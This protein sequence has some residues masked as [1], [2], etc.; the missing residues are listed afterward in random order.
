MKVTILGSGSPL[1]VPDRAGPATLVQVAGHTLLFDCGRAVLMRAAAVGVAARDLDALFVTHMHSDH[2]TD[3][4]DVITTR[5]ISSAGVNPL[6]A[7][8][9]AGFDAFTA[10]T[11]A[12]L[13]ND[14][15]YRIGHHADLNEPPQVHV[16]EVDEGV[17]WE[18]EGVMVLAA[19]TDHSPVHPTVGFRVE[20]DGKSVCIAGDTVPCD[21]LA[22]LVDGADIYVQTVVN[23]PMIE[24]MPMQRFR[25]VLD[26]HSDIEQAAQ[27]AA[28]GNVGTLVLNHPVPPPLTGS[29]QAWIDAARPHFKGEI[30]LATDLLTLKP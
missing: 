9:P 28:R 16:Q 13:S 1:V 7:I 27:T 8:G 10:A 21:G 15:G 20:A 23:R 14:I 29:E 25:D 12:M 4:N 22:R 26:Y 11:L 5:W 3:Y 24:A 17:V 2:T 19:P 6:T 18:A 30:V